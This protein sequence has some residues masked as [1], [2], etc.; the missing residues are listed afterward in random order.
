MSFE[1]PIPTQWVMQGRYL[2]RTL[3]EHETAKFYDE[4][5]ATIAAPVPRFGTID[6]RDPRPDW[7]ET[8]DGILTALLSGFVKWNDGAAAADY[9]GR[10]RLPKTIAI[11]IGGYSPTI[12]FGVQRLMAWEVIIRT[13]GTRLLNLRLQCSA[14]VT[15]IPGYRSL[16]PLN[17]SPPATSQEYER[18]IQLLIAEAPPLTEVSRAEL[19]DAMRLIEELDDDAFA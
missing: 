17:L 1:K 5:G 13:N 15:R 16:D 12:D 6:P 19:L 8:T 3:G 10:F 4:D 14:T 7:P 18:E 11:A 9:V 2:A